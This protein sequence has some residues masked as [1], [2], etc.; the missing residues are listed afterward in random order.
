MP[1]LLARLAHGGRVDQRHEF[2][3]VAGE[4]LV[5]EPLVA[6]LQFR[7]IDILV[8]RGGLLLKLNAL[9]LQLRLGIFHAIGDQTDQT[10]ALAFLFAEG[11]ALVEA[12]VVQKVEA[13]VF[14]VHGRGQDT[15]CR[16]S[17]AARA[18]TTGSA[19]LAVRGACPLLLLGAVRP[20]PAPA[21][22]WCGSGG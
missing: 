15:K 16:A 12:R 22:G 1:E 14:A 9:T 2:G 13:G 20:S 18:V 6:I 5:V 11:G 4:Q 19:R 10:E 17:A 21:P 3:G 7:E 8:E